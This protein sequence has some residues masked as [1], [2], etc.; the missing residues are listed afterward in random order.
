MNSSTQELHKFVKLQ[1]I[2]LV[3]DQSTDGVAVHLQLVVKKRVKMK[4]KDI[5]LIVSYYR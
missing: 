4:S 3:S 1:C 2:V 5:T